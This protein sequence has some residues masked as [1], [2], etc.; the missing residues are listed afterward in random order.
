MEV[1][2]CSLSNKIANTKIARLFFYK[3]LEFGQGAKG[4]VQGGFEEVGLLAA[5]GAEFGF[6]RFHYIADCQV[7]RIVKWQVK[8]GFADELVAKMGVG[9]HGE[10]QAVP[11][12]KTFGFFV[13][14][15]YRG[16]ENFNAVD[17]VQQFFQ[18]VF[19]GAERAERMGNYHRAVLLSDAANGLDCR[20]FIGNRFVDIQ[21]QDIALL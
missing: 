20:E 14:P 7:G 13:A 2:R 1:A 16:V 19:E 11:L 10:C 18:V 8:P 12:R 17:T 3:R 9:T 15:K 4:V 6:D 5:G 21:S